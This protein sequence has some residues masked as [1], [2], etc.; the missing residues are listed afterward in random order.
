MIAGH[1]ASH[2]FFYLFCYL[3]VQYRTSASLLPSV[4][5]NVNHVLKLKCI[6]LSDIV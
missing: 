4:V 1:Q 3:K 2:I 5:A 6:H